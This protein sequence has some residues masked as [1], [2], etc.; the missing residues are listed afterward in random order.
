MLT[1]IT[2]AK[3]QKKGLHAGRGH[4]VG[5]KAHTMTM[6][7]GANSTTQRRMPPDQM[8]CATPVSASAK[9]T[10]PVHSTPDAM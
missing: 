5:T 2:V 1:P 6:I 7:S 10:M 9:A 8:V 4:L 3:A